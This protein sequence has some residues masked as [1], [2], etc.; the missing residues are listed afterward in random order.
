M[1][2]VGVIHA[3]GIDVEAAGP[4]LKKTQRNNQNARTGFKLTERKFHPDIALV[5]IDSERR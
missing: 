3:V 4:S 1:R 2:D 5:F